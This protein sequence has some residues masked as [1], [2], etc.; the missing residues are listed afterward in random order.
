[1]KNWL[2]WKAVYDHGVSE[3]LNA[4]LDQISLRCVVDPSTVPHMPDFPKELSRPW[5]PVKPPYKEEEDVEK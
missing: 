4:K 3:T 2:L 5:E 1:M